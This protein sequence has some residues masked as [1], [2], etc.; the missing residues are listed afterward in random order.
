MTKEQKELLAINLIT[1]GSIVEAA[2]ATGVSLS[3]VYRVKRTE[4]F[5]KLLSETKLLLFNDAMQKAQ[6]LILDSLNTLNE[7][8]ADPDC[9]DSARVASAKAI[10]ELG[11]EMFDRENI[12]KQLQ[13]IRERMK[14]N[15]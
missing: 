9:T 11:T 15:E 5:K 10:I 12:L 14:E 3:T 2:S 6:G 8:R 4:A 7:I 1:K 13:E